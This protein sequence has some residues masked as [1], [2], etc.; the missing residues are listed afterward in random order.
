M[1]KHSPASSA[2]AIAAAFLASACISNQ[3]ESRTQ[4]STSPWVQPSPMLT[5]QLNDNAERL[6]WTHGTER[7]EILRWFTGVGEPAYDTLLELAADERIDVAGSAL[8]ALGSTRDQRL[9]KPIR[10]LD[11]PVE[12]SLLLRL[13]RARAL[14]YLGDWSE[15]PVLIDALESE[16]RAVSALAGYALYRATGEAH[17]F[18]PKA[19]LAER[20]AA[21]E[22]WRSWW[23][24]R[25]SEGILGA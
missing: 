24:E 21:A 19:D 23:Q 2:L 16:E 15:I 14:L 13:E 3:P 4:H 8:T 10:A 6:P 11:I 12:A 7:V 25:Q 1:T 22:R 18:D 9:V 17:G 20:A 5:E